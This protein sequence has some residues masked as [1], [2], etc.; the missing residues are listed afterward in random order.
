MVLQDGRC[1][2]DRLKES[3]YLMSNPETTLRQDIKD[4]WLG[5]EHESRVLNGCTILVTG[6][7]GF[8]GSYFVDAFLLLNDMGLNPACNVIV[9]DNYSSS[10]PM[11]LKHLEGRSDL[12]IVAADV[13]RPL[14]A[15]P[16]CD[17]VI[18][19]ASIATPV[20]YR[21]HPLETIRANTIGTWNL[22]ESAH[23]WGTRGFLMLSTSEVYGDPDPSQ[24]PTPETY[25]GNVNPIGPRAC[26]DESKRMAETL[27]TTYFR[28]HGTPVKITRLFNVYGPRMA[29]DDG[30]LIPDLMRNALAGNPLVLYSDGQATRSLCYVSD[31]MRQMMSVLLRGKDGEVY[32]IGHSQE[33]T[34]HQIALLVAK[35]VG[36]SGV[37]LR[38]HSDPN[39]LIDNP[40]R[41]CPDMRKTGQICQPLNKVAIEQGILQT[42]RWHG[43]RVQVNTQ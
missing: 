42:A 38:Q 5:L 6:G 20:T 23:R 21:K 13:S 32:N 31:A 22:L 14:D 16:K 27:C 9:V 35:L 39:Y 34:V 3:S 7:A 17:Y 18:H 36:I 8:L 10:T 26:Y 24:V 2:T 28:A 41:R 11:N 1:G 37:E 33:M 12:R 25:W 29:L 30:R 43:I 4:I 19:A 40:K 15:L